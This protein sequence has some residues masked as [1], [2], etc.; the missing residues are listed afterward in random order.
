[1]NATDEQPYFITAY[2]YFGWNWVTK[3]D[4]NWVNQ[5]GGENIKPKSPLKP[6]LV[7]AAAINSWLLCGA[8]LHTTGRLSLS[9][10]MAAVNPAVQKHKVVHPPAKSWT[11]ISGPKPMTFWLFFTFLFCGKI[12]QEM[13][14]GPPHN[15]F[16]YMAK[17]NNFFFLTQTTRMEICF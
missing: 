15:I 10:V 2:C 3:A 6:V 12:G 14:R 9:G 1:M 5:S 4:L 13:K 16:T 11:Y 8:A 17:C 7:L